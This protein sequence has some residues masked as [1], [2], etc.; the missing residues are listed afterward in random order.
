[1]PPNVLG[2]SHGLSANQEK[3]DAGTEENAQDSET[4]PN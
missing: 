2:V 3:G 4:G 1:M